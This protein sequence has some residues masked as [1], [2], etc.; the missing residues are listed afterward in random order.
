VDPYR[1]CLNRAVA[2]RLPEADVAR[3][4]ERFTLAWREIATHHEAYAPALAA[5]LAVL[6][7]LSRQAPGSAVS[8]TGRQAFGAVG[9][10]L[11]ADPISLAL[12]LIR[13]F[14]QVKLGAILDL[15]DLFEFSG[16]R[17]YRTPDVDPGRLER[18]LRG[19][20]ANLA[21]C[22]FWRVRA[23]LGADDRAS[24]RQSYRRCYRRTA[25]AI[26]ALQGCESLTPLGEEFVGQMRTG[27]TAMTL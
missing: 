27:L 4:Q 22:A 11:P 25:Q 15:H 5:G 6:T 16:D 24:A 7:P 10:G 18:L 19:A 8:G 14:Q 13:E 20:Y 26:A 17:R 3:W 9:A 12:L 23:T 21:A 2:S 1:R